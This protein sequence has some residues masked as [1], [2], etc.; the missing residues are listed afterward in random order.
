MHL[1]FYLPIRLALILRFHQFELVR[2]QTNFDYFQIEQNQFL[3]VIEIKYV[4]NLID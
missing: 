1:L 3:D 4:G 2:I